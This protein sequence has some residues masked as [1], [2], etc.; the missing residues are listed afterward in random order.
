MYQ[1]LNWHSDMVMYESIYVVEE[2]NFASFEQTREKTLPWM[3]LLQSVNSLADLHNS[4]CP[5]MC[6]LVSY[7]ITPYAQSIMRIVFLFFVP[8]WLGLKQSVSWPD[9]VFL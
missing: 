1:L 4:N 2:W 8:V 6:M 3:Y 9:H 5:T 7:V